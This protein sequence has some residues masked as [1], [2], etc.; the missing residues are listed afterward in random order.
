VLARSAEEI[1]SA[2]AVLARSIDET[3]SVGEVLP[4]STDETASSRAGRFGRGTPNNRHT[5]DRARDAMSRAIRGVLFAGDVRAVRN[6]V[7]VGERIL[8]RRKSSC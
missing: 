7:L 4:R 1:A 3:A 8:R 6:A 2:A 5:M